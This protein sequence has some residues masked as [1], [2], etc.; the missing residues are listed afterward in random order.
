M[1]P[2]S[3]T[4]L[5]SEERSL[6]WRWTI[7]AIHSTPYIAIVFWRRWQVRR[8]ILARSELRV[9]SQDQQGPAV[10]KSLRHKPDHTEFGAPMPGVNPR[11][12]IAYMQ[13]QADRR[14]AHPRV[15]SAQREDVTTRH[16]SA[17]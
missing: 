2:P 4:D 13:L 15:G 16:T 3:N 9:T 8:L 1:Q 11:L 12:A 17:R 7:A 6:A 5:N 14:E 10:T